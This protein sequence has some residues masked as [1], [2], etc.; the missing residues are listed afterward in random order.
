VTLLDF[1]VEWEEAPRVQ[2]PV[3]AATWARLEIRLDGHPVTRFWSEPVNAVRAGV[4]G[5]VFPLAQWIVRNWWHLLE[6]G[7]PHPEVLRGARGSH[8]RNRSW[9]ERHNLLLSRDGMAY[10]DFSV[11]RED[12]FVCV[13]WVPDP[14]DVTTPGRF[15]GEGAARL[16]RTDAEASIASL[17]ESVLERTATF[18]EAET[19]ELRA[20]WEA[21]GESSKSERNL[22]AR[23]A[24]LGVDPYAADLDETVEDTLSSDLG[25]PDLALRDLLAATATERL[26]A[27]L[28]ATRQ[29]IMALP[30]TSGSRAWSANGTPYDPRPYRAGYRRAEVLRQQLGFEPDSPVADVADLAKRLLGTVTLDWI[31]P[32]VQS[33]VEGAVQRDGTCALTAAERS[34]PAQRFLLGR[35]LHHWQ[36]VTQG[37]SAVRLLTRA[38]DWQQSASRAFAAELLAPAAALAARLEG[39]SAWDPQAHE[40]LAREF[41]VSPMVIAHQIENHGLG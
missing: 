7:I 6:E 33:G 32:V 37:P 22:C 25:L 34:A 20:D 19:T 41:Q 24:G 21:I 1:Q 10:P 4:H 5:S 13:R 38:N 27:D 17:V 36:F 30:N 8:A 23:L 14:E 18:A 3:L 35:A 16:G 15:L 11:Y 28:R 9:L 29:L 39:R 26:E 12:E 2:S 31:V 40:E